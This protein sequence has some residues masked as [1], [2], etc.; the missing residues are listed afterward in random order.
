M[1]PR[2]LTLLV[3]ATTAGATLAA[4]VAAAG[5]TAGD[6]TP[7]PVTIAVPCDAAAPGEA[8][9]TANTH[10]GSTLTLAAGCTYRLKTPLPALTAAVT[11]HGAGATLARA[12][13]AP[14]FR[15]L[16]VDGVAVDLSDLTVTGGRAE[17]GT[18]GGGILTTGALTL[19]RVV[20]RDN[21]AGDGAPDHDGGSGGGIAAPKPGSVTA[22]DTQVIG[23][24]AGTSGAHISVRSA[25]PQGGRGGGISIV[26]S[27]L[28][29][30][31]G[32]VAGNRS[33]D[34]GLGVDVA[35]PAWASL[36][37]DGGFGGGIAMVGGRGT[38][39]DSRIC[40][41]TAGNG[42]TGGTVTAGHDG[43][44]GYG[45]GGGSGGGIALHSARL[46]LAG[47]AVCLNAAGDGGP[48]GPGVLH[49]G[50]SGWNAPGG[51]ID[52]GS[53]TL[54]VTGGSIVGNRTGHAHDA[55]GAP[56][57]GGITNREGNL[58]LTGT[59][60]VGNRSTL[61]GGGIAQDSTRRHPADMNVTDTTIADNVAGGTG[62]GIFASGTN[63]TGT[64][65]TSTV[66]GNTARTCGGI[67]VG[68]H[69]DLKRD[70]VI[71]RGNHPDDC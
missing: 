59:A 67:A 32:T 69:V 52:V 3:A 1:K 6:P 63:G 49:R 66:T 25:A 55:P 28:T 46:T 43:Y 36:A 27:T 17:T 16:R 31:R 71:D 57:G 30:V 19:T 7:A 14:D 45:G 23:N 44:G 48:G 42:G 15:I 35:D 12:H 2:T 61:D 39:S 38:V 34:G 56:D 10:P 22:T 40:G 9:T 4:P 60:I 33:G 8:I 11:I 18:D 20:I 64:L 29:L 70:R 53:G 41:N 58:T 37:G 54:V 21:R 26:R 65:T 62:G 5:P 68:P 50:L 24:A 51:G 47:T 13:D